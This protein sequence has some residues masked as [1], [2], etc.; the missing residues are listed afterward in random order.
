MGAFKLHPGETV[1]ANC[2]LTTYFSRVST[3]APSTPKK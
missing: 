1:G 3:A 2:L